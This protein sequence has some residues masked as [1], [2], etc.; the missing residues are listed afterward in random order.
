MSTAVLGLLLV[1]WKGISITISIVSHLLFVFR[2]LPSQMWNHT[3]KM[4]SQGFA[5]ALL[6]PLVPQ[7]IC[8][9]FF[10]WALYFSPMIN[11]YLVVK[12]LMHPE[13]QAV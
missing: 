5:F 2:N 13:T 12:Q 6:W 11:I 10:Y 3:W 9:C 4:L 7:F 1:V 8:N